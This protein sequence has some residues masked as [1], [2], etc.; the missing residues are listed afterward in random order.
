MKKQELMRF[1]LFNLVVLL[2]S[3]SLKAQPIE[4]LVKIAIA[5]DHADWV[6]NKGENVKFKVTVTKNSE[7]L[8]NVKVRYEMGP[9]MMI[10]TI[11]DSAILKDGSI[12]L[13]GGT[14]K[15]AGFCVARWLRS[16]MEFNMKDWQ[17]QLSIPN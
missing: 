3:V 14:L 13:A 5:P 10:P 8:H 9:E 15:D 2:L 4:K 6:Y 16:T 17:Q 12:T 7:L 11:K 1:F